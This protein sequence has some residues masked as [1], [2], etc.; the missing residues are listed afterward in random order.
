MQNVCE[1]SHYCS[2]NPDISTRI[3][4]SVGPMLRVTSKSLLSFPFRAVFPLPTPSRF[5]ANA[6]TSE[7]RDVTVPRANK[8]AIA[9]LRRVADNM[10]SGKSWRTSVDKHPLVVPKH[11]AFSVEHES[12]GPEHCLELQFKWV[13]DPVKSRA[14][15]SS[16]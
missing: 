9:L 4:D 13:R 7:D 3:V 12:E 15:K 5:F 11:A 6:V 8:Q 14:K 1:S 2:F 10:E 16:A